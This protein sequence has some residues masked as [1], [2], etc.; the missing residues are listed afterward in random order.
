MLFR[1]QLD[2]A[3]ALRAAGTQLAALHCLDLDQ[4]KAVNDTLGHPV[5]DALL[6]RSPQR[7]RDGVRETDTVARL[8]GDEFAIVQTD[9]RQPAEQSRLADARSS[10]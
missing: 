5:G 8:G 6:Q 9:D 2:N 10:S 3:L 1:E 7:L 4:F